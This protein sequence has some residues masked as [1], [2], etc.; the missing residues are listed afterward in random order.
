M[1]TAAQ[2]QSAG[3]AMPR[4]GALLVEKALITPAQREEALQL[5]QRLS[6][7][8]IRINCI[9]PGSCCWIEKV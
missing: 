2:E 9:C 8:G 3:V 6:R 1:A 4:I 7:D 5:A